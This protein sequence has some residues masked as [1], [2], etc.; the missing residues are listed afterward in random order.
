MEFMIIR[1]LSG[2]SSKAHASVLFCLKMKRTETLDANS[3]QSL[4]A[5]A[6]GYCRMPG[7][8]V[9]DK[10]WRNPLIIPMIL[11]KQVEHMSLM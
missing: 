10:L 2:S 11:W 5:T 1:K 9:D 4:G 6:D 3:C 7:V 8:W